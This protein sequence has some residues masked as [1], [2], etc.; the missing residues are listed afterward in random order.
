MKV[1]VRRTTKTQNSTGFCHRHQSCHTRTCLM[2]VSRDMGAPL[3]SPRSPTGALTLLC[4][5][6]AVGAAGARSRPAIGD[7]DGPPRLRV[8]EPPLAAELAAAAAAAAPLAANAAPCAS[9]MSSTRVTS[10]VMRVRR[11]ASASRRAFRP[12][13][14]THRISFARL[15]TASCR[16]KHTQT[17]TN[18]H[19]RTYTRTHTLQIHIRASL[20]AAQ[21]SG[22][23]PAC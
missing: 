17:D 13:S 22:P 5:A 20:G 19:T 16:H 14:S 7:G 9:S 15:L 6:R 3:A 23:V 18:R 4:C 10:A 11:S 1:P 21:N 2:S 12:S 8:D